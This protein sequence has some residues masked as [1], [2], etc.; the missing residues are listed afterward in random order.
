MAPPFK[1]GSQ[2]YHFKGRGASRPLLV[3]L[4]PGGEEG[5]VREGEQGVRSAYSFFFHYIYVKRKE[6]EKNSIKATLGRWFLPH[7][8]KC[9]ATLTRK[10][11]AQFP[12]FSPRLF[13][14]T[15]T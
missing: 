14:M 5:E 1:R 2:H 3:T 11:N 12:V 9:S 8:R 10:V 13:L 6:T 15:N 7:A 4:S